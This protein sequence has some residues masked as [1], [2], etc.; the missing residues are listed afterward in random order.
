[1]TMEV[2]IMTPA[3]VR[4]LFLQLRDEEAHHQQLIQEIKDKV[5]EEDGF[6]PDDF[7]DEPA[8]Q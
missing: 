4:E 6:D 5:P 7:V 8:A 3:E 1:M 2:E